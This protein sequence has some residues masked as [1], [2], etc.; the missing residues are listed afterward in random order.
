M[1]KGKNY[2]LGK[3]EI[4]DD[5]HFQ[6]M[7]HKYYF[8]HSIT[9][10]E[11]AAEVNIS[12]PTFTKYAELYAQ[13]VLVGLAQIP[14]MKENI[15]KIKRDYSISDNGDKESV[16]EISLEQEAKDIGAKYGM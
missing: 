4:V 6:E 10:A 3:V 5:P 2:Y 13:K 15:D 8:D 12:V 9:Q 1:P 7:V 16:S 11:A 14:E